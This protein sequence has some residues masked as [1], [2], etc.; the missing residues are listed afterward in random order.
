MQF[1]KLDRRTFGAALLLGLLASD[2]CAGRAQA[3]VSQY[4]QFFLDH[5]P[6]DADR[7][8]IPPTARAIILA[9]VRIVV[10]P[11]W[12]GGRDQSGVP[13]PLPKDIFGAEVEIV[14]ILTGPAAVGERYYVSFGV[15]GSDQRHKYPHTLDQLRHEYFIVSYLDDDNVRRL[16]ALPIAE[17]DYEQWEWEFWNYERER[18]RPG[19][20]D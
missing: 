9:K 7:A 2:F 14:D 20:R 10:R 18:G 1:D 19:A 4:L 11:H 13:A 6:T 3:D 8:H 17:R 12:R 15:P 5:A 16:A